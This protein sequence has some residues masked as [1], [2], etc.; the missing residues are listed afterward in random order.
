MKKI[1]AFGDSFLAGTELADPHDVWP[2]VIA[3]RLNVD[4]YSPAVPG[5]GNDIIASQIYDYFTNN[6]V[7]NTLAV[8]NW[9]WTSR[10]DLY[11][12]PGQGRAEY[13]FPRWLT[14][15]PRCVPEILDELIDPTEANELINFYRESGG[16]SIFWNVFRNLQTIQAVQH[17]MQTRG[18][19]SVQTYMDLHMTKDLD[20]N[21]PTYI[22]ELQDMIRSRMF[23][24]DGHNFVEW[25]QLHHFEVSEPGY[26]PLEPAHAAAA[27][28]WQSKYAQLL[29]I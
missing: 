11:L 29:G 16:R 23:T 8:V 3:K 27:D 17:Y 4:Y 2:G 5:C 10:W 26:H 7:Q 15:G 21:F 28:Y 13:G 22:H 6:P 18:I 1:V 20:N 19:I 14:L 25:C 12:L 9:T 24:F